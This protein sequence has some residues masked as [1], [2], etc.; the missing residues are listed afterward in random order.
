MIMLVNPS[1][2]VRS[3]REFLEKYKGAQNLSYGSPGPGTLPQLAGELFKIKSGIAVRHVPYKGGAPALND[4]IAGH[5]QMTF[6]TP[7]TKPVIDSGKVLALAVASP[8]RIES[9]PDVPTFAE[10]GLPIP[11]LDAG[12]WFGI[13]APA[14]TPKEIVEKLSLHFNDALKYPAVQERLKSL[15]LVAH[16]TTPE[17]FEKFLREEIAR[18]PPIFARAGV[19]RDAEAR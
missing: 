14:G 1:V 19:G 6:G 9:L 12:A 3:L 8:R 15:G 11:E 7:V 5:V 2:G 13:L 10:A 16:G 18:W 4:T 17:E